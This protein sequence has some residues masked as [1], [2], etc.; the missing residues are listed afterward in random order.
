MDT[1]NIFSKFIIVFL[2]F[3]LFS[4]C[5]KEECEYKSKYIYEPIVFD[6]ECNC[7]VA[8]KVKY[9][10]DCVTVILVDYG[11]GTC[12]HMATKTICKNGRCEL[13]AGAFEEQF[14]VD[15]DK[16]IEDGPISDDEAAQMGY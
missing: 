6:E 10:K 5:N 7:I 1:L 15:C 11:D 8:G 3:A 13:S 2:L 12:D 4:A 9:L 14:E 16:I